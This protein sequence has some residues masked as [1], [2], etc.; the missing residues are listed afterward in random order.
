[1]STAG[2]IQNALRQ[3]EGTH[4]SD[5]IFRN[6]LHEDRQYSQRYLVSIPLTGPHRVSRLMFTGRH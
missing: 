2:I 6:G 4:V 1:M 5:Q 3:A